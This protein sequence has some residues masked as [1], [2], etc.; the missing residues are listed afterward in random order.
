MPRATKTQQ[1]KK[2]KKEKEKKKKN[3]RTTMKKKNTRTRIKKKAT[4][5]VKPTTMITVAAEPAVAS[6]VAV[7]FGM[8]PMMTI[9]PAAVR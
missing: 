9:A 5:K 3:T 4:M 6:A 2:K 1:K 8:T 7:G